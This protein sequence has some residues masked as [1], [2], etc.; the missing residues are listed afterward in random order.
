MAKGLRRVCIGP[1]QGH[2]EE[3]PK[4]RHQQ[5][6]AKPAAG[7]GVYVCAKAMGAC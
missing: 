5:D 1:G 2:H 3:E 4:L 6:L 7:N